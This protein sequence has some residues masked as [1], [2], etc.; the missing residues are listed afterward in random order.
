MRDRDILEGYITMRPGA[1]AVQV[2]PCT[3]TAGAGPALLSDALGRCAGKAVYVDMPTG[4]VNAVGIVE[5]SGLKIQ[6]RFTRMCR[7]ERIEDKPQNIWAGSG[8]EKG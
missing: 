4:N 2:G 7:G 3:A 5:S 1:N 6:R 8:P